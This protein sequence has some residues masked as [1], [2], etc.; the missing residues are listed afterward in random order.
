MVKYQEVSTAGPFICPSLFTNIYTEHS[1]CF[2][3]GVNCALNINTMKKTEN[4]HQKTNTT[5]TSR[6]RDI[7][8]NNSTEQ[9][10]NPYTLYTQPHNYKKGPIALQTALS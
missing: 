10:F 8:S 3:V 1:I 5:N 2:L 6:N 9:Y 7:R 4:T